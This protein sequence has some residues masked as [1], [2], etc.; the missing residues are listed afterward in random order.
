MIKINI[1]ILIGAF[2]LGLTGCGTGIETT[3]KV[4]DKDVK[5]VELLGVQPEKIYIEMETAKLAQLGLDVNT[6]AGLI[7][8][9]LSVQASGMLETGTANAYLRLT[10]NAV[11]VVGQIEVV[12]CAR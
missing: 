12:P 11:S 7:N 4:T 3:T 2:I 5:K 8:G 10:G 6:L 1:S 9:Q